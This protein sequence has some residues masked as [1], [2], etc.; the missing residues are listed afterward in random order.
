MAEIS[1]HIRVTDA[2]GRDADVTVTDF[3]RI[4]RMIPEVVGVTAAEA[5]ALA[6]SRLSLRPPVSPLLSEPLHRDKRKRRG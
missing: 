3:I 2:N 6:N 4:G 1:V 5:V